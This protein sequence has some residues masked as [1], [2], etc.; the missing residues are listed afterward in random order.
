MKFIKMQG[1]GNDYIFL[2]CLDGEPADLPEL[3]VRMSDR[4]FGAGSDGLICLCPS[5]QGDFR[6]RMFNADGSEG[7]MCGN[8]IRCLAKYIRDCGLSKKTV[9]DIETGAGLRRTE[10]L[11]GA[12]RVD[13]GPPL[14]S[15]PV[16]VEALGRSWRLT[17]VS[18]G[19]P[20]GVIFQAGIGALPLS[21]IGP[22]LE[23]HP[24]FPGGINVE[25]AEVIDRNTLRMRVW[26]RGSGE[27]LACGTGACA[28]L[29][30]AASAGL[31]ERTAQ[32]ELPG[33]TLEICWDEHTIFLIGPAV[34]VYKGEYLL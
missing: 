13:M 2:N 17:P 29:A 9:L 20:H 6:M 3:A 18:M 7:E 19:N 8:G 24:A 12:V 15:P 14:V 31:T 33:G 30:A 5:E 23:Q 11:D 26:E 1:L 4:H 32:V 21:T 22:A 34:T 27:T 25:F 28:V 10:L 16:E